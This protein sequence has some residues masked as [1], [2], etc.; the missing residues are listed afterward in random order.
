MKQNHTHLDE[1]LENIK[2]NKGKRILI[3]GDII[4]DHYLYGNVERISPEAPVPIVRI[5]AEEY[6]LG[7]AANV[8]NNIISLGG[9]VLLVGIVGD[10]QE[11]NILKRL[12]G[13]KGIEN[14]LI[15]I[16]EVPVIEKTR[17]IAQSQHLLRIDRED[18]SKDLSPHLKEVVREFCYESSC[19]VVSDYGKGSVGKSILDVLENCPSKVL[20]DPKMRNYIN[21]KGPFLITPNKKEAEEMSGIKIV[22]KESI[23]KAGF[24]IIKNTR[25]SNLLITLGGKGM[26]LFE[27]SGNRV[28]HLPAMARKVYDVTGAG[29]TVLSGIALGLSKGAS[30][31]DCCIFANICAGIVV[32]KMGTSTPLWGE[33]IEDGK[34][35]SSY[36]KIEVW[37][38]N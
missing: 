16:K 2:N 11:G 34:K 3:V 24:K 15:E 14:V 17:I 10:G 7:G 33:I 25:A 1:L 5:E 36:F 37:K 35:W 32:G 19:V 6:K 31:L 13:E 23:I 26:V 22:D 28:V 30:L 20:I 21:Y 29:D 12:L 27:D 4:L 18:D 38:S 9:I 8:A